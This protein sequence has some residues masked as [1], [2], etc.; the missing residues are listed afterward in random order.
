[1]AHPPGGKQGG[2]SKGRAVNNGVLVITSSVR[3]SGHFTS[4]MV[5]SF[6]DLSVMETAKCHPHPPI[7]RKLVGDQATALTAI[8]CRCRPSSWLTSRDCRLG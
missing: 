7:D 2:E 4:I 3:R 6:V 5:V 8:P 1:M